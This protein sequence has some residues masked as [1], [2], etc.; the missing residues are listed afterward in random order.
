MAIPCTLRM[1]G[2]SSFC[3]M[4]R[5]AVS[6]RCPFGDQARSG[7]L[8]PLF[9][10][11]LFRLDGILGRDRTQ[12]LCTRLIECGAVA[13][14]IR[15][16]SLKMT[17]AVHIGHQETLRIGFAPAPEGKIAMAQAILRLVDGTFMDRSKAP[18]AVLSQIAC[19]FGNGLDHRTGK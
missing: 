1:S 9:K 11:P 13:A 16:E 5:K 12:I 17:D 7:K 18:N 8:A 10:A 2:N 4:A 14:R 15:R 3:R 6:L 19:A